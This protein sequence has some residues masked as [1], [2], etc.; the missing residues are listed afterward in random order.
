[1][2]FHSTNGKRFSP[3]RG[4]VEDKASVSPYIQSLYG[5]K[6][7][8]LPCVKNGSKS[9]QESIIFTGLTWVANSSISC[10][11]PQPTFALGAKSGTSSGTE[12]V[13]TAESGLGVLAICQ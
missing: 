10:L 3:Q 7:S 12:S 6:E 2:T 9:V 11:T 8:M 4:P 13:I 5:R 1:M